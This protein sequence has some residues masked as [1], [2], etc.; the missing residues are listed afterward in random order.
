M[1]VEDLALSENGSQLVLVHFV[2]KV[3]TLHLGCS[4]CGPGVRLRVDFQVDNL[5]SCC[6]LLI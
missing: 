6:H 5:V 1:L 4:H 3:I 2:H